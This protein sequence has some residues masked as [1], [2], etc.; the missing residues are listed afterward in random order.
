MDSR[1][2]AAWFLRRWT[3]Y[4]YR[5]KPFCLLHSMLLEAIESPLES[6]GE[7]L[8]A[9]LMVAAE[10][11]STHEALTDPSLKPATPGPFDHEHELEKWKAYKAECCSRPATYKRPGTIGGH[12][13]NA[14]WQQIIVT[15]LILKSTIRRMEAWKMPEGQ[16]LWQYYSIREQLGDDSDILSE[17]AEAEMAEQEREEEENAPQRERVCRALLWR[18][19]QMLAGR[20][21]CNAKGAPVPFDPKNPAHYPPE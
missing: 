9:D 1:F 6:G 21:P 15:Y 18:Q 17:E 13:L 5:L 4:G 16:A 10:I 7:V 12:S 19:E 3:V 2:A 20:W 8:P 14:P 11:C